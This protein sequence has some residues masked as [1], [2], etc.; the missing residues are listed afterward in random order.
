MVFPIFL[1]L[2][3]GGLGVRMAAT[4]F[5]KVLLP[6]FA[7]AFGDPSIDRRIKEAAI[8]GLLI[9]PDMRN[10]IEDNSYD[11]PVDALADTTA[12]LGAAFGGSGLI[13]RAIIGGAIKSAF[14]AGSILA[15][16]IPPL[17]AGDQVTFG[18]RFLDLITTNSAA[19]REFEKAGKEALDAGQ[20][21]LNFALNPSPANLGQFAEQGLESLVATAGAVL[22]WF[23]AITGTP[24]PAGL[25]TPTQT[26]PTLP[27]DP[28]LRRGLEAAALPLDPA[29][30]NALEADIATGT[31]TAVE[32]LPPVSQDV[33]ERI[34][35]LQPD[36]IIVR[37]PTARAILG[38]LKPSN[39]EG[40]AKLARAF[41]IF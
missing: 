40:V 15:A 23:E 29:F 5:D 39:V 37:D 12:V 4:L 19:S 13:S 16:L 31:D 1:I 38:V 7:A 34:R 17:L 33:A 11:D 30:R 8:R 6:G 36:R 27:L 3:A 35:N 22:N 25:E 21:F 2:A 18:K 26:G 9:D 41:G 32:D 28:G 24:P 20:A 14:G 10:F